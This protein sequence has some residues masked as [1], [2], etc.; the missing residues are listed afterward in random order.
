[1]P[2]PALTQ[3]QLQALSAGAAF[4]AAYLLAS[5]GVWL[6]ARGLRA[7]PTPLAV[8][9]RYWPYWPTLG[10]A[11]S[12]VASVAY[13]YVMVLSAAFSAGVNCALSS[14]AQT[15]ASRSSEAPKRSEA[16]IMCAWQYRQPE[17]KLDA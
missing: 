17:A 6:A 15:A 13:P 10:R 16:R 8:S 11:I 1:L 3:D 7:H 2:L 12:L 4:L 14:N 9:V 5:L